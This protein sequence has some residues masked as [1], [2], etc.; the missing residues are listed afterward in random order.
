MSE[1][2]QHI[3]AARAYIA[4]ARRRR[5]QRFGFVL[6]TWAGNARRAAM[7]AGRQLELFA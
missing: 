6:L 4:E 1:R 5:G 2:D 3:H 7:A